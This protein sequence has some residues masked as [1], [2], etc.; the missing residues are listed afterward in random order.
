MPELKSEYLFTI[1][2]T[3]DAWHDFGAVPLGTRH[4]DML[5]K[6]TFEGPFDFERHNS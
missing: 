3:V 6:G 1:T 5:G 2:V 4:V